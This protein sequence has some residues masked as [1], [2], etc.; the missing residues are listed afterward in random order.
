MSEFRQI[1]AMNPAAP[2]NDLPELPPAGVMLETHA[3]LKTCIRARTAL[4]EMKTAADLIPNQTVLINVLPLLEARASTEVENIVTTNDELFRQAA[5]GEGRPDAATKEALNYRAALMAGYQSLQG[6]PLC[7]ATAIEVC[8][9]IKNQ[10]MEIRRVPGTRLANDWTGE[11]IYTPPEGE[12]V[13]RDKLANWE[14][15]MHTR[16]DLDPLV[17]MAVAHYQFEAIHP[18]TD[19]NG[20]TGRVLNLLYLI[21]EGLVREPV[22]YLSRYILRNRADYYCLLNGVTREQAWEPWL[23]FMLRGVEQ[24]AKWTTAKIAAIRQLVDETAAFVRKE[25]YAIYS[26]E[27]IEAIYSQAYCRIGNLVDAGLGK[28]QTVAG[29]LRRLSELGVLKEISSGREKLF[30]NQRFAD[31]LFS[32]PEEEAGSSVLNEDPVTIVP[33]RQPVTAVK[34][35]KKI[36]LP[37]SASHQHEINGPGT[38]RRVLGFERVAGRMRW[39]YFK[40][41]EPVETEGDFTWYDA[42]ARSAERTGRSEWRLYYDRAFPADAAEGD[43]LLVMRGSRGNPVGAVLAAGSKWVRA[44]Q[45]LEQPGGLSAGSSAEALFE[46]LEGKGPD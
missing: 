43:L 27:L 12:H 39:L 32:D 11:V 40:E 10:P 38:F 21:S 18:F 31:L 8:C 3:V 16:I 1:N 25:A 42:R 29:Y 17:R 33:R 2:Y 41:D 20:R 24:T 28:R 30:L 22:L 14:E 19:G 44:A 35:L 36:D 37:A 7:T 5:M 34:L 9:E 6:R 46:A 45:L 4:M 15:F 23:L 26:R 13:L